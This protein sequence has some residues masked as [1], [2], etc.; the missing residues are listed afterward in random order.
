MLP[1]DPANPWNDSGYTLEKSAGGEG[2]RLDPAYAAVAALRAVGAAWLYFSAPAWHDGWSVHAVLWPPFVVLAPSGAVVVLSVHC[3]FSAC[4]GRRRRTTSTTRVPPS[5]QVEALMKQEN[6]FPGA[7]NHMATISRLEARVAPAADVAD[8]LHRRRLRPL[9]RRAGLPR[10]EWRHPLRAL[11][12]AAAARRNS[13]SGPISTTRGNRTSRISSPTRRRA[14]PRSG[15][16]A[17]DFRAPNGCSAA[18]PR[19]TTG[20]CNGRAGSSSPRASGIRP[21]PTSRRTASAT[22]RP[23]GKDWHPRSS[24]ADARDWLALFGS[25]PRP[26]E[27]AR[28]QE[29]PTLVF[30]GLSNRPFARMPDR[31]LERRSRVR[32][33]RRGF[34]RVAADA[35]YGDDVRRAEDRSRASRL[36]RRDCASSSCPRRRSRPFPPRSSRACGASGA[37]ASSATSTATRRSSGTGAATTTDQRADALV[38]DLRREKE[39]RPQ[40]TEPNSGT[41]RQAQGHEVRDHSAEADGARASAPTEA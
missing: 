3:S 40:E 12:A 25:A 2:A 11:D 14:S 22:T 9:R 23:F 37:R 8:R 32:G 10:Q 28:P 19:T 1:G 26:A 34:R 41:P 39:V 27:R 38:L 15:A 13:C 24:D 18:A 4:S 5:D 21:I 36:P 16:T 29:I 30:G 7:Q 35:T 20:S 31:P 6:F 17:A 33:A